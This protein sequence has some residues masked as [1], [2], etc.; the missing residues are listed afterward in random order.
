MS[1]SYIYKRLLPLSYSNI[2]PTRCNITQF[3]YIWTLL[4]MFRVAPPP[5]I[6]SA[7]TCIYSIWY[8]SHRYSY[9]PLSG[10]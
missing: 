8:L 6:R 1:L 10:R 2:Y 4:Y 9:L 3:I 5:I 7:N